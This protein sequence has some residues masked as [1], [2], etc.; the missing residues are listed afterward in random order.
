M[1]AHLDSPTA[2]QHPRLLLELKKSDRDKSAIPFTDP[3]PQ[4]KGLALS[5]TRG[6]NIPILFSSP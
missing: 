5:T 1:F 3:S 4:I 6:G 2:G